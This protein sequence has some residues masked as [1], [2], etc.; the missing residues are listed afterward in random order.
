MFGFD[1][2]SI[3]LLAAT[4]VG[5]W[6]STRIVKPKDHERA[7]LLDRIARGAVSLVVLNN[8]NLPAAKLLE[9]AVNQIALSAG[10]SSRSAMERA[11]AA[12]L[13]DLG[14]NPGATPAQ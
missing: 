10:T 11:A 13:T 3:V 5:T 12:A 1:L 6:L 7:G 4:A 9:M 14:K 8:P 2:N